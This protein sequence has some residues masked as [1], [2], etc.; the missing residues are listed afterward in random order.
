MSQGIF[1]VKFKANTGDYGDGIVVVKD[2]SANGGGAHYLYRGKVP[3]HSGEF[4]SQFT[5]SKW[6]SGNTNVVG[7]DNYVLEAKGAVD[8]EGGKLQL[9]GVVVGQPQLKMTI[10]GQ[11][12]ADAE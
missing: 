11:K 4:Q 3:A 5:I 9:D 10:V 8:Y 2:G 12:I 1:Y 6:K 7:I